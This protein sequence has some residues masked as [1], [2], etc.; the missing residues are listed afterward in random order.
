MEVRL[1]AVWFGVSYFQTASFFPSRQT[2]Q[3][4]ENGNITYL[5][6]I[7]YI[8]SQYS[9][10]VNIGI[11]QKPPLLRFSHFNAFLFCPLESGEGKGHSPYVF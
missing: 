6:V 4:K 9:P 11:C 2:V 7:V 10:I 8:I 3:I 5:F 1:G